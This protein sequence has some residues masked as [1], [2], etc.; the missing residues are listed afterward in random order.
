MLWCSSGSILYLTFQEV[1]FLKWKSIFLKIAAP[2][3]LPPVCKYRVEYYT[4][5]SAMTCQKLVHILFWQKSSS[6]FGG[7]NNVLVIPWHWKIKMDLNSMDSSTGHQKHFASLVVM[8]SGSKSRGWVGFGVC[9]SGS[10]RIQGSTFWGH[11]PWV[12]RDF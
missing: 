10:G 11:P 6:P 7:W 3:V 4:H 5:T 1:Q 8:Y 9:F 2:L 12:F